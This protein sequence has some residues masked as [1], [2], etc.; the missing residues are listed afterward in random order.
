M[1]ERAHLHGH[2]ERYKRARCIKDMVTNALQGDFDSGT[3][4]ALAIEELNESESEDELERATVEEV[5]M[6]GELEA[7]TG[8]ETEMEEEIM[9]DC[10]SSQDPSMD[11]LPEP[12]FAIPDWE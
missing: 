7:V 10:L 6:E 11:N 9:P 8:K 12:V 1:V 2:V 5:K 4:H 3:T